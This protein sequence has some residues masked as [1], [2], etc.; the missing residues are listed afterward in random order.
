M[1]L[2]RG[3]QGVLSW[4]PLGIDGV[5]FDHDWDLLPV[6][7]TQARMQQVQ[8]AIEASSCLPAIPIRMM[9]KEEGVWLW[10]LRE[11]AQYALGPSVSIVTTRQSD[12]E[13]AFVLSD[14]H[15]S[16]VYL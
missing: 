11:T 14:R 12:Q 3:A 13:V 16:S 7:S 2:G 8:G 15:Q 9:K 5:V 10:V 6:I 1:R 4:R